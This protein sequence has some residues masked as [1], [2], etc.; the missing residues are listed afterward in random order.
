MIKTFRKPKEESEY[1]K[2]IIRNNNVRISSTSEYR[3]SNGV[4][5][6][7]KDDFSKYWHSEE[8]KTYSQYIQIDLK[9]VYASVSSYMW[10]TGCNNREYNGTRYPFFSK[11]W[12][13]TCSF[14]K[15][16]NYIID[17]HVNEPEVTAPYQTV[18]FNTKQTKIC[19]S[20]QIHFTG[21]DSQG[22][23]YQ[24]VG[25][26]EFY[27]KVFSAYCVFTSQCKKSHLMIYFLLPILLLY[28]Y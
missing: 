2:G 24:Y 15:K 1:L 6:I 26:I 10:H 27:G 12:N 9:N 16:K 19:N 23:A 20:F 22:R 17:Y 25:L 21:P 3:D 4:L 13:I 7:I 8:D 14:N 5:S 18:F 11:Y 28:F